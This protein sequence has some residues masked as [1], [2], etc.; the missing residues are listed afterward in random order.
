MHGARDILK[1]LK[2][3]DNKWDV[4]NYN[5]SKIVAELSEKD[6]EVIKA[7]DNIGDGELSAIGIIVQHQDLVRDYQPRELAKD[8][9]ESVMYGFCMINYEEMRHGFILKE[10]ASQ[11]IR[12]ESFVDNVDGSLIHE[13]M[14]ETNKLYKNPYESLMSYLLGEITNVELY[15]SVESK[16]ENEDL[17]N[18]VKQIRKD[19]QVHKGAWLK[20]IKGMVEANE[21]HREN[22]IDATK[23]I[24]FVHQAEVSD[25]FKNGAQS[26]EKFFTP[27]VSKFILD[28]KYKL[29]SDIFGE[30]P[31]DKRQMLKEHL[32]Y[33]NENFVA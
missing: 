27:S 9:Y 11:V 21:M 24:H 22:F 31:I 2:K 4:N 16:V 26:V 28:E 32:E 8:F 10:L 1:L 20:I 19:E 29:L 33:F 18:I 25:Y 13:L 7:L 17:K 5:Y 30:S 3:G 23:A 12:G 15:A 6:L 14:F